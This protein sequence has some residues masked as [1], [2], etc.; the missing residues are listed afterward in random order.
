V[1][2]IKPESPG[3]AGIFGAPEKVLVINSRFMSITERNQ[4]RNSKASLV[5]ILC[6]RAL[7]PKV[8]FTSKEDDRE[9]WRRILAGWHMLRFLFIQFQNHLLRNGVTYCELGPPKS[10]RNHG[11]SIQASLI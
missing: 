9:A 10:L 1:L 4:D 3:G 5:A 8:Y 2:T 11:S 6:S 7:R